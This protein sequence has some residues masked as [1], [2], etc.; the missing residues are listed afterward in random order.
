MERGKL[1]PIHEDFIHPG[2]DMNDSK[3]KDKEKLCFKD[4]CLRAGM[5][6][7]LLLGF[8][9]ICVA[10]PMVALNL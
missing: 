1:R 10:L 7:I 5:W 9:T 4:I 8:M 3:T 6:G 2:A